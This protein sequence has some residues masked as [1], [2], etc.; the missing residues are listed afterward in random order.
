LNADGTNAIIGASVADNARGAAWV[1]AKNGSEWNLKGNKMAGTVS[2]ESAAQG[3]SVAMSADGNTVL[4]GAKADNWTNGAA[5]IFTWS[6]NSWEQRGPKLTG[7]GNVG[8]ANQGQ[9]LALSADGSTAIIGG[10]QDTIGWVPHGFLRPD[11]KSQ[12]HLKIIAR[13][14]AKG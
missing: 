9:S 8:V 14:F 6:G 2:S 7:I 11:Q 1:F 12:F 10:N 13:N 3:W 4:I 5:W